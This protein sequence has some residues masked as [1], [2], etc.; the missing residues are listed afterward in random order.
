MDLISYSSI[1]DSIFSLVLNLASL[2]K[3]ELLRLEFS[4]RQDHIS[5]GTLLGKVM[6]NSVKILTKSSVWT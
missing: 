4:Y 3:M 6:M 5:S 1:K 2:E